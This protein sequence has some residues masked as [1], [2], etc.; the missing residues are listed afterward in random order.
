MYTLVYLYHLLITNTVP[1]APFPPW[2]MGALQF[3]KF[4][5]KLQTSAKML[6]EQISFER[7]Q[8]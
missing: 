6:I 3:F 1:S 7:Q 5:L 8:L 4:Q 2:K